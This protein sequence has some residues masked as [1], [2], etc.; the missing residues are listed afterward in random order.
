MESRR[1]LL[2]TGEM[3][4][5]YN[6]ANG[7][8]NLFRDDYDYINFLDKLVFHTS[9]LVYYYSYCLMPN[10][11]HLVCET[12]AEEELR[13]LNIQH[14][15]KAISRGF[16]NV[17]SGYAKKINAKYG[18]MGSLFMQNVGKRQIKDENDFCKVVHYV[19]ANPVHH[20]F[21][22]HISEWQHSSYTALLED[23]AP[24]LHK[25]KVLEYFGNIHH[26]IAYHQQV[27]DRK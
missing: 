6:H 27:I 23:R 1:V 3:Y 21:V 2:E 15:E 7:N 24:W 19:H 12:R 18:R 20:G 8:E 25:K 16:A 4:H 17:F 14:P 22:N 13:L 5:L 10:H 9:H 26:F 11:F